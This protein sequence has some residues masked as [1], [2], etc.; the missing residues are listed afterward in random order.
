[1][2]EDIQEGFSIEKNLIIEAWERYR[3]DTFIG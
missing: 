3:P 1:M 2:D